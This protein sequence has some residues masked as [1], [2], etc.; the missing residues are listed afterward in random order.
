MS[1]FYKKYLKIYNIVP[2]KS[3]QNIQNPANQSLT[4]KLYFVY[5]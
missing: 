2:Q 5:D 1:F 4:H 3:I